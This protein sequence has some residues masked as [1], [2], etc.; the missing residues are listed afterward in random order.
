MVID[1]TNYI[2]FAR[3][4]LYL[5]YIGR[6]AFPLFAFILAYNFYYHTSD[7]KKYLERVLIFALISQPFYFLV[8]HINQLNIFFTLGIG[9]ACL[10]M[11]NRKNYWYLPY[12]FLPVIWFVLSK[13]SGLP[14]VDYGLAGVLLVYSLGLFLKNYQT[15]YGFLVG[16]FLVLINSNSFGLYSL[17]KILATVFS[18]P[19]VYLSKFI[20]GDLRLFFQHKYF[21]YVFYP[22]HLL[23]LGIVK[24]VLDIFQIL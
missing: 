9:M 7:Q 23:V 24:L 6:L 21:F 1:H 13:N 11:F 20:K 16:I 8:F 19:L 3:E 12:I 14:D 17:Y 4:Y 10:L 18:A 22:G 15:A 5:T 2:I